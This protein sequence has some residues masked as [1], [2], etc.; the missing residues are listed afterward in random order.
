M[1]PSKS[2]IIEELKDAVRVVEGSHREHD[3][4]VH[5][6]RARREIACLK[7]AIEI[8]QQSKP[9]KRK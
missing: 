8:V 3:G 4:V 6:P 2:S 7:A 9:K 5:C 1:K